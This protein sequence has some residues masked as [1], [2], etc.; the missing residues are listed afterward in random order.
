MT[1]AVVDLKFFFSHDVTLK[2]LLAT[3]S[4]ENRCCIQ[5]N[6]RQQR[7]PPADHVTYL[8]ETERIFVEHFSRLIWN[9][10]Y[11]K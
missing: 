3:P 10:L 9:R 4:I 8:R 7:S 11:N 5:P 1:F 6:R 2:K